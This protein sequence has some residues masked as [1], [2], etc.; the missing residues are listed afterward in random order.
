[1]QGEQVVRVGFVGLGVMGQAMAQNLV[2]A[3]HTLTV[4]NRTPSR[5]EPLLAQGAAWAET[6]RGAAVGNEVVITMVTDDE[7]VRAVVLGPEGVL[8]GLEP[9]GIVMDMST[10]SPDTTESMAELAASREL[11]WVDA[12]VTGGDIGAREGTLTIMAGGP[13]DAFDRVRPLLEAMGQRIVHVGESG[14][15]QSLKLVGNLISGLNLLAAAEG[16][17]LGQAAGVPLEMMREVLPFSSAQ[18]FELNKA[19]DRWMTDNFRPG[20]SVA[21][22]TKDLRLAV[23]MSEAL[24]FTPALAA[25]AYQVWAVHAGQQADQDEASILTRWGPLDEEIG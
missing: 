20:F 23:E 17:R 13:A 4:Y 15:G 7:A 16:L 9:G 22:R 8:A 19:F 1:M 5:A 11:A 14:L 12:P 25:V 18:S 24:N 21:N 10:I 2:R 3:G 6:P